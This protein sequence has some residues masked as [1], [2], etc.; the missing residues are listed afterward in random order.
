MEQLLRAMG[1]KADWSGYRARVREALK[2]GRQGNPDAA[3]TAARCKPAGTTYQGQ[4]DPA[5]LLSKPV[6]QSDTTLRVEIR[7]DGSAVVSLDV[8]IRTAYGRRTGCMKGGG[9]AVGVSLGAIG[10]F[11]ATVQATLGFR[12]VP[13]GS[14]DPCATIQN[15]DRVPLGVSGRVRDVPPCSGPPGRSRSS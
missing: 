9:A 3:A 13:A 11:R 1:G 15:L 14:E 10:R 8:L 6:A 5:K 4:V 2:L 7:E 12:D